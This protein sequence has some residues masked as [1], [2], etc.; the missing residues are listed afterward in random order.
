MN[1]KKLIYKNIDGNGR[2]HIL[3]G[4]VIGEDDNFIRF[5]TEHRKYT[6]SKKLILSVTDTSEI[7]RGYEQ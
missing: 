3:L 5:R 1:C 7:F 2:N 4:I 6:V